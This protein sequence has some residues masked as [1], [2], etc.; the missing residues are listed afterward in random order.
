MDREFTAE[1]QMKIDYKS[2][3]LR[4]ANIIEK[5]TKRDVE[6]VQLEM[7]MSGV[8]LNKCETIN[9]LTLAANY[10]RYCAEGGAESEAIGTVENLG[11]GDGFGEDKSMTELDALIARLAEHGPH[12]GNI[13]LDALRREAAGMLPDLAR[14]LKDAEELTADCGKYKADAARMDALEALPGIYFLYR[15]EDVAMPL[16]LRS[17]IDR[18]LESLK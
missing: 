1:Q 10:L 13:R 9:R 7:F 3:M 14:R 6:A 8:S 2:K 4:A 18:F 11:V 5:I 12:D 17:E 15:P 16:S